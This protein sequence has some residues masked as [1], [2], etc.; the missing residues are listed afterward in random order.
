M[1]WHA[2]RLSSMTQ[3]FA[4]LL[5]GDFPQQN[6]LFRSV[7]I[8]VPL[9]RSADSSGKLGDTWMRIGTHNIAS[10]THRL[11]NATSRKGL[12]A[13]QAAFANKQ[14]KS[15]RRVGLPSDIIQSLAT[16]DR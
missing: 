13:R 11:D 4:I 2:A 8:R 6:S 12:N 5:M 9:S 1:Y 15:H 3:D 16:Q 10:H 14:Y 7:S